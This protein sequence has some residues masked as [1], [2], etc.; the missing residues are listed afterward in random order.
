M[1][2]WIAR[3]IMKQLLTRSPAKWSELRPEGETDNLF[4]Y[5]MKRL[6]AAG[7][8]ENRD[9][10]WYLTEKGNV[11]L[12][13]ISLD[14]MRE[15]KTPKLC[16]MLAAKS[17]DKV[18]LYT[19]ARAPYAGKVTVPY[20]RWH[21]G[22]TFAEAVL[23][24]LLEKANVEV[25]AVRPTEATAHSVD[26]SGVHEVHMPYQLA[27]TEATDYETLK[28]TWFW[29]S[30]DEFGSI[31]WATDDHRDLAYTLYGVAR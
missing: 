18:A 31:A 27:L 9:K 26:E 21:R 30:T 10:Q 1:E 15:T 17:G 5:Y 16:V 8:I 2:H 19:W 12:S 3:H 25:P 24:E 23:G 7:L 22:D 11:T 13:D 28:G 6:V 29:A 20:G 4:G 14:T